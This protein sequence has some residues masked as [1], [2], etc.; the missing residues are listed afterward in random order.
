MPSTPLG[1]TALATLTTLVGA[2]IF[3]NLF[4]SLGSFLGSF[5]WSAEFQVVGLEYSMQRPDL[6]SLCVPLDDR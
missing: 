2:G 6:R 5:F 4:C 3:L 1:A